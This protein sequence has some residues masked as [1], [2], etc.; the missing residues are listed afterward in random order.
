MKNIQEPKKPAPEP[1][2]KIFP[3]LLT[4]LI[5]PTTLYFTVITLFLYIGGA[6]LNYGTTKMI[7][8]LS[9]I[10][11]V[12]AFSFI[13]NVANLILTMKKLNMALR[14]AIHYVTLAVSFFV[15]FINASDYRASNGL[16]IIL[17]LSYT[18]VY[19]FICAIVFA[20]RRAVKNA[21]TDASEYKSIY[22]KKI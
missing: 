21:D 17:L 8:R 7:P 10:L 22:D 18:L 13:I 14:V 2:K 9:T 20:V 4:K 1:K 6:A 12:L 5:Y 16:T 15:L 3:R 19:A 11:I